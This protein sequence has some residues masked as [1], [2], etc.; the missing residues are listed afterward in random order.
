LLPLGGS[1]RYSR[2]KILERLPALLP[3]I[4]GRYRF[5][6]G[7]K[8]STSSITLQIIVNLFLM[9]FQRILH[10]AE[11]QRIVFHKK[12]NTAI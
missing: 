3:P 2:S 12:E 6:S 1:T 8:S 5:E 10:R 9:F 7:C 11:G 4:P